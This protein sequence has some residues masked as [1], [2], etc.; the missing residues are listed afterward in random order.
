ML[1]YVQRENEDNCAACGGTGTLLCCDSC[2]RSFHF[3]CLEPPQDENNS[4]EGSWFC[5]ACVAQEHDQAAR[6]GNDVAEDPRDAM[7]KIDGVFKPLFG[8][9]HGKIERSFGLP[10]VVA[11]A[12]EGVKTGDT[13]EY[14]ETPLPR[15]R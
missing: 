4:P 6:H 9:L 14:E 5:R 12:F 8:K 3:T 7:P 2:V 10:K 11:E 15:S 1:I 13:G